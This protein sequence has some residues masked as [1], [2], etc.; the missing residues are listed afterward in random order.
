MK[1]N[2]KSLALAC[3]LAVMFLALVPARPGLRGF[4]SDTRVLA[5]RSG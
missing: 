3:G 2:V 4:R 5:S 1:R